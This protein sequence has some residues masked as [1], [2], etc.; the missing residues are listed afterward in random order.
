MERAEIYLFTSD[1]NEGWGAVLNESMNS[2]CAVIAN[3]KIGSVPF[4]IENGVNGY[5][6]NQK[7]K[8]NLFSKVKYLLDNNEFRYSMQ[9]KAYE[10]MLN[11]WNADSASERLLNLIEC[12]R[13]GREVEYKSGPCSRD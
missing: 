9:K 8:D 5:I 11:M 12:L 10:T 4:L 2:A 1:R 13:K 7:K 3:E 6:Y